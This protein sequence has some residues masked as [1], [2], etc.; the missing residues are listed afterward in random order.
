MES[1][2]DAVDPPKHPDRSKRGKIRN[3]CYLLHQKLGMRP[4]P[5][6]YAEALASFKLHAMECLDRDRVNRRFSEWL[7]VGGAGLGLY[8][9]YELRNSFAHGSIEFPEPDEENKALSYHSEMIRESSRIILLTIQMLLIAHSESSEEEIEYEWP[10]GFVDEPYPL[11]HVLMKC[12]L[13][14]EDAEN[15]Q[16][17]LAWW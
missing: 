16:M 15:G 9:V 2:I 13:E 3:A 5:D 4:L 14:I 7:D 11:L 8:V 6:G 12:H 1:T 10:G 17:D